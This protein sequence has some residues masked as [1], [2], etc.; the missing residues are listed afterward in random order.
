[1]KKIML[2]LGL[3]CAGCQLFAQNKFPASAIPDSLKKGASSVMRE[4]RIDF[5]V[6]EAGKATYK[7]HQVVTVLNENG[8]SELQFQASTDQFHLLEDVVIQMY[9]A[10]GK[11]IQKFKRS[12]LRSQLNGEGLVPDG[13]IYFLE[14]PPAG[15]PVTVQVDCEIEF[16][17]LLGYPT[18]QLQTPGQSVES[19]VI[20][21][22]VPVDLDLR[23]KAKNT[24][25]VP[26]TAI[27][28]SKKTYTWSVKNLPAMEQE[29]E[30]VSYRTSFP[31]I[32]F[33]PNKFAIGGFAGD[34]SSWQS[35][36]KWITS[37]L[38][39]TSNLTEAR[40]E[41]FRDLVKTAASDREKTR[42]IYSYLQQNFR[43]VSIQLGIGGWM[44]FKAGFVDEKKYGDCK[45]LSNYTMACLSAV[46][47]KS[48]YALINAAY[49]EEPVDKD[50]PQNRFNHVILCVPQ[51]KDSIW[52]ECTSTTQSF[53]VLG[54]GTENRY[55]L[56]VTDD[57]G[58]LVPT[59]K[60]NA[61]SNMYISSSKI[62][63]LET[64]SGSLNLSLNLSGEFK[65][66]L[67]YLGTQKKDDQRRFLV[68]YLDYKNP[69]DF[70][71]RYDTVNKERPLEASL[72]FEKIPDFTA[73]KK[74]FLNPR[75]YKLWD[76]DLPNTEQRKTDFYFYHPF[77]KTDTTVYKLPEGF[78]IE[79]LPKAKN[80]KCDAG[81]FTANYHY[82]EVKKEIVSIAKLQL[83]EY[84]IPAA[85]YAATAKFFNEVL[86][87]YTEKIVVKKL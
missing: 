67:D 55:A 11:A 42:I 21:V 50:F 74:L 80:V 35:F 63:L 51:P 32:L 53:G 6:K 12:D 66:A 73:G 59:P 18:Y 56:L 87:E 78:A 44:P 84:K 81:M 79:A 65:D 64:G 20:N 30:G 22:T 24:A 28:A 54:S 85:K 1:M 49:N 36:G 71:I 40:K 15:Y 60:S 25:I 61:A 41:F 46:G 8:K 86:A 69:D 29:D 47:I 13:K 34:M 4:E 9:D 33:A 10:N 45:A 75:M 7:F 43:Y 16:T 17:G 58:K 82:D 57:G 83:D 70:E 39:N 52:L 19:S 38:Q 48:H 23:F 68:N 76:R 2:V 5:E 14:F 31:H 3:T 37:M 27:V 62:D 26:S 77:I 72:S